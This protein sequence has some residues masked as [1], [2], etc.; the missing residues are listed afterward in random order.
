VLGSAVS[1]TGRGTMSWALILLYYYFAGDAGIFMGLPTIPPDFMG[2][3]LPIGG[4]R[5]WR[6]PSSLGPCFGRPQFGNKHHITGDWGRALDART[7][8]TPGNL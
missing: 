7:A 8:Y 5:G 3:A 4:D 6:G 2:P 1:Q